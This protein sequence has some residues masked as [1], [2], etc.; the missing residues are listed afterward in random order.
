MA[1]EAGNGA[2]DANK[3]YTGQGVGEEV[4]ETIETDEQLAAYLNKQGKSGDPDPDADLTDE[5]REAKAK[6]GKNGKGKGGKADA[7]TDPKHPDF[8][9]PESLDDDNGEEEDDEEYGNVVEYLNKEFNLGLNV[10]A[11]PKDMT[12]EQEA[13]AIG[14]V[15]KRLNEG[16]QAKLAEYA[17]LE[18]L[19]EDRE[20]AALLEAKRNGKGLKDIAAAYVSSP[21]GPDDVVVAKHLK[22]MYPTLTDAEVEE[23]IK[24]YRDGKKLDKMASAARDYFKKEAAKATEQEEAARQRE[25]EEAE[26]EYKQSVAQFGNFLVKTEKLYDIPITKDV[27]QKIFQAV[28]V[29]DREGLTAHDRALQSDAGTFLSALGMFFMKEMLRNGT[30]LRANKKH[31]DFKESLFDEPSKLQGGTEAQE[32]PDFN[33][34]LANSF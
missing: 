30:T 25:A 6:A 11:L 32:E 15:F 20:V 17:D 26:A 16:V 4:I 14:S 27:K 3:D 2:A 23:Q 29:R 33:E 10:K 34:K 31:R 12:R 19:L 7:I 28:T 9:L 13:E 21:D 24:G 18:E 1:K 8:K 5:E 22:L